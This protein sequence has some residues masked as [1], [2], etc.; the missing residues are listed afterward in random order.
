MEAVALRAQK[1][2]ADEVEA[3][4]RRDWMKD[5]GHLKELS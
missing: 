2:D 5:R 1:E 3:Q 4:R